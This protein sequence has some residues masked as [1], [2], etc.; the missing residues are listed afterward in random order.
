MNISDIVITEEKELPVVGIPKTG[1]SSVYSQSETSDNAFSTVNGKSTSGT[2]WDE[3]WN[4]L[5]FSIGFRESV[6]IGDK[7]FYYKIVDTSILISVKRNTNYNNYS[8]QVGYIMEDGSIQITQT[9]SFSNPPLMFFADTTIVGGS[10]RYGY[11]IDS[12][13][14]SWAGTWYGIGTFTFNN[15]L[16]SG[17]P[18]PVDPTPVDP[19]KPK[20]GGG[21][22][23]N[24]SDEITLPNLPTITPI[25]NN[26][27]H[28]YQLLRD[29]I[30]IFT[31][32]TKG[33]H[34]NRKYLEDKINW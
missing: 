29:L 2:T 32:M 1:I 8:I 14:I 5:P 28:C 12:P 33:R 6:D 3:T 15:S 4:I 17:I 25:N 24:D 11:R 20:G 10:L 30:D 9:I 7:W 34:F 21:T 27:I 13:N 26:M 19:N 18:V 31:Q 16:Y 23:D 22:R